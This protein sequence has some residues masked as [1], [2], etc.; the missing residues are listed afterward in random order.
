MTPAWATRKHRRRWLRETWTMFE[1]CAESGKGSVTVSPDG[2]RA[3]I[4]ERRRMRLR[5]IAVIVGGL[6]YAI[7]VAWFFATNR[8]VE[9][10]C[11]HDIIECKEVGR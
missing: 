7:V 8:D 2:C 5:H 9:W 4:K 3:L 6:I 11:S 1:E 10:L